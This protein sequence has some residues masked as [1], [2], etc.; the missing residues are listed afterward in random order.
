ME[1]VVTHLTRMSAPRVCVAGLGG[2]EPM[3][4]LFLATDGSRRPIF[5][6]A[7][8]RSVLRAWLTSAL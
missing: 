2:T 1:I 5:G 7:A 3:S 6:Q 8:V 4:D